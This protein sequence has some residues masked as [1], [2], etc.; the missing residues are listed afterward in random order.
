MVTVGRKQDY[1][2]FT[3]FP[4]IRSLV[5]SSPA[6][7]RAGKSVSYRDFP[8]I[9]EVVK[10]KSGGEWGAGAVIKANPMQAESV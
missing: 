8:L 6:E 10:H 9:H 5:L 3:V 4:G 7:S 1:C 2:C